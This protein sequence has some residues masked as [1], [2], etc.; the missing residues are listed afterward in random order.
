MELMLRQAA[1]ALVHANR[2]LPPDQQFTLLHVEPFLQDA[3]FRRVVLD[4]LCDGLFTRGWWS[5]YYDKLS[6]HEREEYI[7]PVLTKMALFSTM[8]TARRI[9]G[10]PRST[11]DLAAAILG[12]AIVVVK[13]AKGQ[14][15]ADLA[16]LVGALLGEYVDLAIEGQAGRPPADAAAGAGGGRRAA[17][18]P[19]R[20]RADAARAAQV[21]RGLPAVHAGV[22]QPGGEAAGGALALLRQRRRA[23]VLP[24][25][26]GRGQAAGRRAGRAG[27]AAGPGQP[28]AGGVRRQA[29]RGR[30]AG[31]GLLAARPPAAPERRRRWR[32]TCGGRARG[33]TACRWPRPTRWSRAGRRG[34]PSWRA[35][36]STAGRGPTRRCAATARR[37]RRRPTGS[38]AEARRR[39]RRAAVPG[40][41]P[42]A[43]GA[44]PAAAAARRAR[45]RRPSRPRRS[46]GRRP[47][48]VTPNDRG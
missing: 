5:S 22:R 2:A 6:A 38:A 14:V 44:A 37:R 1:L 19:D 23:A 12:G 33:A 39:A 36:P 31:A 24:G 8:P 9:L 3:G 16:G 15:K 20:L 27:D 25:G 21:R 43:S 11:L 26:R 40:R 28:G 42:S 10:Q 4:D 45:R 7:N 17:G 18:R 34:R 29:G 30:A 48:T 35:A 41:A 32:P 13:L 47:R 46:A